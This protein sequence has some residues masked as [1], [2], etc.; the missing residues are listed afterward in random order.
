MWWEPPGGR[1]GAAVTRSI[2]ILGRRDRELDDLIAT[3]AA[4][5]DVR[6]AHTADVDALLA[7]LRRDQPPGLVV[8]D[9]EHGDGRLPARA[10]LDRI[11]AI[12]RELPVVV[13]AAQADIDLVAEAVR[14]GASD[15][16]VRGERLADRVTTLLG[17]LDRLLRLRQRAEDD[18]QRLRAARFH[19]VGHS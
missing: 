17:K 2:A 8:L 9:W 5:S 14:A 7:D 13:V 10:V 6:A 12:D 18:A 4:A 19:M 3:F 1:Y 16:L 11:R 15:F